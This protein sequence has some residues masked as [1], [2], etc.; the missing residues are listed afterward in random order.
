MAGAARQYG[1]PYRYGDEEKRMEKLIFNRRPMWLV[2]ISVLT[3][4]FGFEMTRIKIDARFEK[5]L[6]MQ[7]EYL[8][9]MFSRLDDL[10]QKG[11]SFKIAIENTQG[12][13]FEKE[14]LQVV[15][16]VHDKV[17][18]INGV[19][20]TSLRS[21]WAPSV[22][23]QAVTP[24]G[25]DGDRLIP[26]E[27]DGSAESLERVKLNVFR[28]TEI[29]RLISDNFKSSIVESYVY[30]TYPSDDPERGHATGDTIDFQDLGDILESIRTD[31]DKQYG[32]KYRVYIIGEPKMIGDFITGSSQ[33]VFFG[34]IAIV[35]TIVLL[36]LYAR[37]WRAALMPLLT[38][39]I[40]VVWMLGILSVMSEFSVP[41]GNVPV[42][43]NGVLENVEV[44]SGIGLFSMLV[45]FLLV[46]IG[47]SHSVQY[48]NA[49]AVE[50]ANG[51]NKLQASRRAFRTNYLPG[52]TALL[53][54]AFSFLT[55]VLI[56][57]SAIKE[58]AYTACIG[59]AVLIVLKLMLLPILLSYS[60]IAPSGVK[61]MQLS[62]ENDSFIWLFLAKFTE[63]KWAI[64]SLIFAGTLAVYSVYERQF[65]KIGDIAEGAPELRPDSTYNKDVKFITSNYAT[66]SDLFVTMVTTAP[67]DCFKQKNME[68]MDDLE[69]VLNNTEGV[70]ATASA[71]FVAKNFIA[72]LTEG[73]I[74]W[75]ALGRN[76][77]AIDGSFS[78]TSD[79]GLVNEKCSFAP[80]VAF[81]KDHK[82][83][84]LDRVAKVVKDFADQHNTAEVQFRLATGNAG[85]AAAVNQEIHSAQ[86][87]MLWLVYAVVAALVFFT[88]PSIKAMLCILGPLALT[89]ILCEALMAKLGIGV[90]VATLPVIT[91]GVGVGVDYGIYIYSRMEGYFKEG[92]SLRDAY[93]LT[94]KTTGKAVSFTGL[95]LAL[96]VA[97]W[98]WSAIQFQKDMGILLVFMFLWN[99]VG[100]LTL[101]PALAHFLLPKGGKAA[102]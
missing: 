9:N 48:V 7:H 92:K 31:I 74:K 101:L 25:F 65:L 62:Q 50:M 12:D 60:G 16:N 32:G 64:I 47:V 54:N 96:G 81:L 4:Y 39:V 1:E 94:L 34:A 95:T 79:M 45:P 20:R 33:I 90:K 93:L 37:C 40:A 86:N 5:M 72:G 97:T 44:F 100:A 58:L 69:W 51:H 21:M 82:A 53:T 66:S 73:H 89:S 68:A 75:M 22:R 102:T 98:Y 67:N 17:F 26:G 80:V 15:Q 2:I 10:T 87:K 6:P 41:Y 76:Q 3:L 27:Y 63:S 36:Y 77:E 99:M 46:A 11:L 84:T 42:K 78:I 70:Q 19:D 28:S 49:M 88:F 30:S 52:I 35:L 85:I 8:Q 61:H 43:V 14:Y 23:W 29:G 57:I 71:A 91:L 24:Q 38:S 13:I 18:N 59:T 56:P 83:E 55:M